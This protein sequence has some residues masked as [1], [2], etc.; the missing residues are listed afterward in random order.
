M[1][2][3]LFSLAKRQKGSR[4]SGAGEWLRQRTENLLPQK[5]VRK[6]EVSP[7]KDNQPS[8]A[9]N[10]NLGQSD[11]ARQISL[12]YI[13]SDKHFGAGMMRGGYV[14]KIP[15]AGMGALGVAGA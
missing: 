6:F 14:D 7:A 5:C 1:G 9:E 11:H 13:A 4:R 8:I 2:R 15:G 12:G 3:R 10:M